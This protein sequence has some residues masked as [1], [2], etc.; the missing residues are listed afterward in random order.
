MKTIIVC[1][2]GYSGSSSI[3]D[4]LSSKN[5]VYKPYHGEEFR[6][7]NDPYGIENLFQNFY[8]NFSI[9]NSSEAVNNFIEYCRNYNKIKK[10]IS[11]NYISIY[12]NNFFKITEKYIKNITYLEYP[13]IPQFKRISFDLKK[14]LI[15]QLSKKYLKE[16]NL[17]K[18]YLPVNE[19]K[20]ILETKKYLKKIILLKKVKN[21]KVVLDQSTN[22]WNPEIAFK[23]FDQLKIIRVTRDP[24]SV[25]LSF[26]MRPAWA[27][28][29]NNINNFIKWY[30]EI[31]EKKNFYKI[32]SNKIMDITFE[33]FVLNYKNSTKKINKFLNLKNE[34]ND[35][36]NLNFSKANVFKAKNLLTK[37]ELLF[38]AKKLKKYLIWEKYL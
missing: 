37:N 17:Y 24:R 6:L 19:K 14:K 34:K 29:K 10:K 26:K 27:Y 38:L 35:K 18:M 2:S 16:T 15:L 7:I 33:E 4:Y 36:F 1:G 9:N 31:I 8:K 25:Y 5:D 28:P 21:K 3:S 11:N 20:F 12:G 23:Y 22:F 30:S 32:R 13:A